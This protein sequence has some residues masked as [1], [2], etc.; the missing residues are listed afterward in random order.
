MGL[1]A[2]EINPCGE[3]LP[4]ATEKQRRW[5]TILLCS[6]GLSMDTAGIGTDLECASV[7]LLFDFEPPTTEL[8]DLIFFSNPIVNCGLCNRVGG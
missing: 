7:P 4:V 8:E 1:G 6:F 3:K 5:I 2:M